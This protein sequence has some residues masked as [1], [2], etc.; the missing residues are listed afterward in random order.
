MRLT[1]PF[2]IAGVALAAIPAGAQQDA[3]RRIELRA[4]V[5]APDAEPRMVLH[6]AVRTAKARAYQ[7]RN[8]GTEQTDQFS[9]WTIASPITAAFI[10][11][12]YWGAGVFLTLLSARERAWARCPRSCADLRP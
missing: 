8:V 3:A 1:L 5:Q 6:E 10:G 12:A 11:A 9:A 4:V 7:G 2:V